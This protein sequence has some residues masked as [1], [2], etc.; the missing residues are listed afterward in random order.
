[1]KK[2]KILLVV[3][4]VLFCGS[5]LVLSN[6]MKVDAANNEC[7]AGYTKETYMNNISYNVSGN[8][9]T[10]TG[11]QGLLYS[12]SFDGTQRP[13]DDSGNFSFT[14]PDDQMDSRIVVYFYLAESDGICE[15]GK[16]VG[17]NTFYANTSARNQL[18]DDALC[19]NYR[20]KWSNNET[21]KAA[22]PYC[23]TEE[24]SVQY[25][26]DE[27]YSWIQDAEDL[28]DEQQ[29]GSDAIVDDP[30]YTNVDNV[31]NT[32]KLTCDAFSTNNY[33]TMHKYSHK[34]TETVDNCTTTC[35]EEI[36][37]NF[38]DPVATQAGLCFQYLIE[39]KSVV[40]CDSNY[41][42]P[43]PSRPTV[44]IPYPYCSLPSGWQGDAHRASRLPACGIEGSS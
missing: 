20:N 12:T 25:T 24:V 36:E 39:I 37:V 44:C 18:Y 41:I 6:T 29:N 9:V 5:F 22:V 4:I 33:E 43:P 30:N 2:Y 17:N 35:K 13:A 31:K 11:A 28:Y 8:V 3:F 42:A 16:E 7:S 23:F 14:I 15:A 27:V 32:D 40:E 19:V 26:Y 1:M 10:F 21:M 38:S 34:E